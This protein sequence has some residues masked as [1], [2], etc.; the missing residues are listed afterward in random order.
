MITLAELRADVAHLFAPTFDAPRVGLEVE[1]IASCADSSHPVPLEGEPRSVLRMVRAAAATRGWSERISPV[2]GSSE[3]HLPCGGR[4]TFEPGGQIEYSAPAC[5]SASRVLALVREVCAALDEAAASHGIVLRAIGVDPSTPIERV[6]P[7]LSGARYR[8]ML[9]HLDRIG[10]SGARMMR[11]TAS[12]QVTI[13]RGTDPLGRWRLLAG[14]APIVAATFANSP[15][16]L[17]R[18][19]GHRSFRHHI[20]ATLD[21]DRTGVRA[22]GDDPV[23]EYLAFALRAP[24]FLIGDEGAAARP[25]GEWLDDPRADLGAWRTHLSTLFPEVRARESYF[26]LRTADAVDPRWHAALTALTAGIAYHAPS[27]HSAHALLE[28]PTSASLARAGRCALRDPGLAAT[29][30]AL[31]PI[32]LAACDALGPEMFAAEDVAMAREYFERYTL[33]GR[34]PADE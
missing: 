3:F 24:A 2:A 11:Q 4:I 21:P 18:D 31:V 17:G 26:E 14:L 25:F 13:D 33:K 9:A 6:P 30:A 22:W 12:V 19:T 20:W 7:Q 23:G 1:L 8:R 28:P 27:A 34:T 15:C 10:P 32:A 29:A 5:R 16:Y